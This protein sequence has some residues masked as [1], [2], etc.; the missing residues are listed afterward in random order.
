MAIEHWRSYLQHS[1][2]VLRIDHRS[3]IHLNDQRI[4]TPWQQKALMKL[5]SFQY[6]LCYKKGKENMVA[7]ALSRVQPQDIKLEVMALSSVQ[8]QWLQEIASSY[9]SHEKSAQL[10]SELL[11]ST[12]VGHFKLQ[13]GIIIY[14]G[15]IW[16]GYNSSLQSKVLAALHTSP[17]GGHSG[18]KVTYQKIKALFAWPKMKSM[19]HDFVAQCTICQQTKSERVAYPGLLQPLPIPDQA[20]QIVSMDFIEG[21]PRSSRFNCIMV[22]VDKFSKYSHFV[23]LSHPFTAMI[24][25][26]QFLS[27]IYK[28]HGLPLSIISDRDK[29][30]TSALWQKLF[31]MTGTELRMSTSYHLQTD[32]QT[33][34]VNQ[35]LE[36]YL[37]CFIH[38]CPTKWSSWLPLAEFGTTLHIIPAWANHHF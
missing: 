7:D 18:V 9:T 15:R 20:Y 34:R 16:L 1:E 10:F 13:N 38:A 17:V 27:H 5:M 2:F 14:K 8:P 23:P 30:F 33:E 19:I 22:V 25:A 29:V 24:V 12:Q 3:L 37:R 11:I 6:R 36:T 32:G 26:Q 4:S 31:K 21:L 28:L 35:C